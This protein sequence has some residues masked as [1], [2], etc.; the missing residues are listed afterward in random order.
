MTHPATSGP[1]RRASRNAPLVALLLIVALAGCGRDTRS[2]V[3]APRDPGAAA[4]SAPLLRLGVT[5]RPRRAIVSPP[6]WC[7]R[8]P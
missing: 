5:L 3:T 1:A 6:A 8:T 4:L 2:L 7:S